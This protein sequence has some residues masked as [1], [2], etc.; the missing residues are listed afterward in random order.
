MRQPSTGFPSPISAYSSAE[1][2]G[3]SRRSPSTARTSID[4]SDDNRWSDVVPP[5][6]GLTFAVVW[7]SEEDDLLTFS[8][9]ALSAGDHSVSPNTPSDACDTRS[10]VL[11]I[12][13]PAVP[14]AENTATTQF[15][16][17][18]HAFLFDDPNFSLERPIRGRTQTSS[19]M[20]GLDVYLRG[21]MLGKAHNTNRYYSCFA[22]L[23]EDFPFDPRTSFANMWM[24]EGQEG[25]I[26][27][28]VSDEGF[29]EYTAKG[30]ES[31]GKKAS[32]LSPKTTSDR[33]SSWS[34]VEPPDTPTFSRLLFP[35]KPTPSHRRLRK[36]RST[37]PG[38]RASPS[39]VLGRPQYSHNVPL[40]D[41]TSPHTSPFR[42]LPKFAR[43]LGKSKKSESDIGKWVWVDMKK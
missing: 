7:D 23:D 13:P 16:H 21:S 25:V 4:C 24:A 2:S 41:S 9:A 3:T 20:G 15:F 32:A 11:T 17:D 19:T 43:G 26:R 40:P 34:N 36:C 28:D 37:D 18:N 38:S 1:S 8:S 33:T 12:G 10:Q 22:G 30:K 6:S 35:D 29:F 27:D 14:Y 5:D 39:A 31:R 42:S